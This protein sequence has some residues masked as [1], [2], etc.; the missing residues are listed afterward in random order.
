M[1]W[2]RAP[3]GTSAVVLPCTPRATGPQRERGT[4]APRSGSRTVRR[5]GLGAEP[6]GHRKGLRRRRRAQRPPRRR[7][8]VE[9]Y[10]LATNS[11]PAAGYQPAR[12]FF[13]TS[14]SPHVHLVR[15]E[16]CR[17]RLRL[18]SSP[19]SRSRP[20]LRNR[21]LRRRVPVFKAM[22]ADTVALDGVGS[23]PDRATRSVVAAPI[24]ANDWAGLWSADAVA[25]APPYVVEGDVLVEV[26][27]TVRDRAV[28]PQSLLRHCQPRSGRSAAQ[29]AD[30]CRKAKREF[31]ERRGLTETR[32]LDLAAPGAKFSTTYSTVLGGSNPARVR[33]RARPL[34][35][36][37]RRSPSSP[38]SARG[39]RRETRRRPARSP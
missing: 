25:G 10:T 30:R 24:G 20:R 3:G 39:Q 19:R 5:G 13:V 29:V 18:R 21:P 31:M 28:Y 7:G 33:S 27:G 15:L 26:S 32:P 2:T 8:E 38:R 34:R 17:S 23:D 35:R 4:P 12:V 36:A 14:G 9:R 1:G 6:P 37:R 11:A 16:S 22:L